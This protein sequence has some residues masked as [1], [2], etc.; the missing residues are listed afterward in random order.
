MKYRI[1]YE[2]APKNYGAWSPDL[3]GCVAVGDTLD[4]CR[5]EM[6]DAI[7]SHL[8]IS[9]EHGD[10]VPSDPTGFVEILNFSPEE[11]RATPAKP[12]AARPQAR[13]AKAK[14]SQR[15][16]VAATSGR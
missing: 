8:D 3:W 11:R 14:P 6:R 15:R 9:R 1:F 13:Q 10:R 4:E 16:K 2:K 7:R 5:R 12:G